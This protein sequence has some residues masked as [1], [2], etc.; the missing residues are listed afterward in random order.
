MYDKFDVVEN[1]TACIESI[2][3]CKL[4][5]KFEKEMK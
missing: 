2:Q 3:Y 5:N 1:F 4:M